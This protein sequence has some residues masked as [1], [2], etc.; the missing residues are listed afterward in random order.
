MIITIIDWLTVTAV[1]KG[2]DSLPKAASTQRV[3]DGG[4]WGR[5]SWPWRST[6]KRPN[7]SYTRNI[8]LQYFSPNKK[9][10]SPEGRYLGLKEQ[11]AIDLSD[12]YA[13]ACDLESSLTFG[14]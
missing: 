1:L 4:P 10:K 14:T 13:D 11:L 6:A 3:N 12:V 2:I 5:H 9:N 7:S 8:P